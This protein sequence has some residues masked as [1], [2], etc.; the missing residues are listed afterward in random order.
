MVRSRDLLKFT[1]LLVKRRA[2]PAIR[3]LGDQE[4]P[5]LC[6]HVLMVVCVELSSGQTSELIQGL[7]RQ[8]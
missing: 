6:R 8:T 3:V 2:E 1:K 7:L 4:F 5:G